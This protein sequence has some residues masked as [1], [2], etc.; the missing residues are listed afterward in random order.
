MQTISQRSKEEQE[1]VE[2][3]LVQQREEWDRKRKMKVKRERG[4]SGNTWG[5]V[6]LGPPDPGPNGGSRVLVLLSFVIERVLTVLEFLNKILFICLFRLLFPKK[7][8]EHYRNNFTLLFS[9]IL[10]NIRGPQPRGIRHMGSKV[11]A[12]HPYC[13]T[14]QSLECGTKPFGSI[15]AT[16]RV[17]FPKHGFAHGVPVEQHGLGVLFC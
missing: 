7:G 1:K 5:G 10:W 11:L 12:W 6:S 8:F 15:Q 4:W 2:A 17:Q 3:D 16:C 14:S 13:V 9:C